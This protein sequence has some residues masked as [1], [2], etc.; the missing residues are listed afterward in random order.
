MDKI[1]GIC[2]HCQKEKYYLINEISLSEK[3]FICDNLMEFNSNDLVKIRKHLGKIMAYHFVHA[4][5]VD[6]MKEQI[7]KLGKK[8]VYAIIDRFSN[9]IHR[10]KTRLIFQEAIQE[11][12]I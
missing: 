9:P 10:A 4:I 8:R 7:K 2:S 5:L 11:E 1:K 12:N 6:R 3:C